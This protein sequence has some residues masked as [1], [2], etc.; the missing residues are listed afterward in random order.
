MAE[1]KVAR[2]A[3]F[4]FGVDR[5][6]KLVYSELEKSGKKVATLGPIIHNADVVND[7]KSK[8]VRIV[9]SVSELR[10]GEE[11]VIRSHG[12]GK[13]IYEELEKKGNPY[14]DATCPFVARIHKIVGERK[15]EK[16]TLS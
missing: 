14:I 7:L 8:G 11:A 5:A 9:D 15:A 16:D 2:T 3:G 12:V 13:E 1:I 6:V 4:C 10:E